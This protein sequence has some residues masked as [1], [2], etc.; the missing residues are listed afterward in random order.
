MNYYLILLLIT[1]IFG[2]ILIVYFYFSVKTVSQY[3]KDEGKSPLFSKS[4]KLSGVSQSIYDLLLSG[5]H[6]NLKKDAVISVLH[7]IAVSMCGFINLT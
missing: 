3:I 2:Y 1:S 7:D 6:G 4:G 5:L